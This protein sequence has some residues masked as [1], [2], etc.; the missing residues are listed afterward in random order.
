MGRSRSL[1]HR[2][3]ELSRCN[4]VHTTSSVKCAVSTSNCIFPTLNGN[5]HVYYTVDVVTARCAV[6]FQPQGDDRHPERYP[7]N[8][9]N[10]HKKRN[11]PIRFT[12]ATDTALLTKVLVHNPYGAEGEPKT[13][14][15][16]RVAAALQRARMRARRGPR[17]ARRL[18]RERRGAV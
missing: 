1:V 7:T 14:A 5:H 9:T 6:I 17:R 2:S 10:T 15:W 3:D 16:G 13:A 8:T 12:D 18:A 4:L 11:D